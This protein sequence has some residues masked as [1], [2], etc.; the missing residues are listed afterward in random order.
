MKREDLVQLILE[1]VPAG[2]EIGVLGHADGI[3]PEV[4]IGF[5]PASK[6]RK[7]NGPR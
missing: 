7:K 1:S 6:Q 5:A 4:D 3:W 2:G